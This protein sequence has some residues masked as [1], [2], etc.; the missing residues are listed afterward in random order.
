MAYVRASRL[1]ASWIEARVTKLARGFGEGSRNPWQ[2]AGCA[3]QVE[4]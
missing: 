2:A 1:S 3:N 4:L